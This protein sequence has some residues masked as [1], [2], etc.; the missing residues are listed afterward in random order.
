MVCS[1]YGVSAMTVWRWDHDPA[2][3]FPKPYRIRKAEST[4][5]R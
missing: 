1:R 2:L 4:V 3:H 5:T